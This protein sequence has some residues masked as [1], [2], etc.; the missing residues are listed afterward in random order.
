MRKIIITL[1]ILS[2]PVSHSF[3]FS[4]S[5][6]S[7]SLTATSLNAGGNSRSSASYLMP[8]DGLG[9]ACIGKSVSTTYIMDCGFVAIYENSR[10]NASIIVPTL[11]WTDEYGYSSGGVTNTGLA[12]QAY[13]WR[14]KYTN[15]NNIAPSFVRVHILKGGADISGSPFIMSYVSGNY[16]TGAIYTYSKALA[17]GRDYSY[18]FQANDGIY[19]AADT[20]PIQG[21]KVLAINSIPK[22]FNYPNPFDPAANQNTNIVFN[23]ESDGEAD[24][25][26]Y[27]EM[28]DL[29]WHRVFSGLQKGANEISYDGR[30]DQGKLMYNGPYVCIINKKSQT[31]N[32]TDKCRLLIIK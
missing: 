9:E 8:Q 26:I 30:D 2:Y 1:L 24:I 10:A 20:L 12:S 4:C 31:G 15:Q 13:I 3:A 6:A 21:P 29:C 18:Y 23:M 7:Y 5:S 16:N 22:A 14:I 17:E 11:A 27:S 28:G 19:N 25:N 32:S